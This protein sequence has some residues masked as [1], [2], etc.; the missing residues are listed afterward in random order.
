MWNYNPFFPAP[1]FL[2]PFPARPRTRIPRLDRGGIYQVCTTGVAVSADNETV[3]F[4][5]DANQYNLLP[6]EGYV[7][8]KIR[9]TVPAAGANLPVA[10]VPT[11]RSA[12]PNLS[13]S[14]NSGSRKLPVVDHANTP[15]IGSNVTNPTERFAYFNK[16]E[17]IIRFVE[18]TATTA[19]AESASAV[20]SK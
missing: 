3:D 10:I 16:C 13:N 5:I 8:I 17:N 15:V 19:P 7:S 14:L 2:C 18:F 12:V 1:S 6:N 9:H 11:R 20:K 4:G